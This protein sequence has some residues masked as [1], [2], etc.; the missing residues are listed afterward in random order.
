LCPLTLCHEHFL[1]GSSTVGTMQGGETWDDKTQLLLSTC[2]VLK[3]E[4]ELVW[5]KWKKIF[6]KERVA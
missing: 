5:L 2:W 1:N 3:N 4:P 6:Q